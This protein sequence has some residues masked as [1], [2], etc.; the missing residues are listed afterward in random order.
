LQSYILRSTAGA[1]LSQIEGNLR[2][3][4]QVRKL[5]ERGQREQSTPSVHQRQKGGIRVI[6][7]GGWGLEDSKKHGKNKCTLL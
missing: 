7:M 6:A 2:R 3:T 5:K 1:A 4:A